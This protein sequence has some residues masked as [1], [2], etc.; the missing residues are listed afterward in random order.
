MAHCAP[1]QLSACLPQIVPRLVEAGSDPHP[2]VKEGA[3][4]A[5]LDISSVIRNPEIS[6]L[7]PVLLAAMSDPATRTKEA[8]EALL[9]TEF[10]HSIDAPSLALLVPILGRALRD[11][12]ADLKRKSSAITGNMVSMVS[13]SKALVPY[14]PQVTPGLQDCLLDPIPDVRA[15]AAKALGS[16]LGGVGEE[17]M[18]ELVPWLLRTLSSEASPTDR[19]GSAQGLAE[20]SLALGPQRMDEILDLALALRSHPKSGGREGLLWLLSFMP[21]TLTESF[22]PHI[23]RTLPVI[24]AGLS[25]SAESVREVALRA[26][27]VM[28]SCLGTNHASLLL[29]SLVDGLF[30]EDW[31]IRHSSLALLGDLLYLVAETK[32]A[33]PAAG[34][35]GGGGMGDED[36]DDDLAG[37]IGASSRAVA[38][39]RT[40]L[41]ESTANEVLAAL[42]IVRADVSITVRQ[43]ALQVWKAVV[44]NTPRVLLEIIAVLV[45]QL[46]AKLASPLEDLRVVAGRS[47]GELVRKLGDRV[48]PKVVPHLRAQLRLADAAAAAGGDRED[49][50]A[51]KQGVCLGLVEILG[52]ASRA[53]VE[54]YIGTLVPALQTA[55]CDRSDDVRA[56]AAKGFMTLFKNIG[57]RAVDDVVPTLLARLHVDVA[58]S[59]PMRGSGD[60]AEEE[61]EGEGDDGDGDGDRPESQRLA[62]LGLQ[63]LTTTR[64][65]DLL[66]YL[67]DPSVNAS[68]GGHGHQQTGK[69]MR[70]PMSAAAAKTLAAVLSVSGNYLGSFFS[71]LVPALCLELLTATEKMSK[72]AAADDE[73]TL[74]VER[75]RS[76][77]LKAAAAA[78]MGAVTAGGVGFLISELS[79]M[80]EHESDVRRRC[81]GAFLAE[82]LFRH[83]KAPYNDL[84]PVLLKN[85]LS[86]VAESDRALLQAVSDAMGA[87]AASPVVSLDELASHLTF[88]Q[89]CVGSTASDARHRAGAKESLYSAAGEFLLPLFTVPK[90]LDP[91]LTICLHAL[92]NGS[93]QQRETAADLITELAQWTEPAALKPYLIKTTG[94]LIRVVGDRFPSNVKA[95]I[96]STLT[97]LLDRGGAGLKAFVPQL[98]TTFV[99]ALTDSSR[100]V[101]G[102]ASVALGRLMPLTTRVDPLVVELCAAC[103]QAEGSAIRASALDA[104]AVVLVKGGDKATK[105]AFDKVRAAACGTLLT[106][107]VDA[108]PAAAAC[109]SA[110]GQL[111]NMEAAAVTDIVFDLCDGAKGGS[112]GSMCGALLGTAAIMQTTGQ[113]SAEARDDAFDLLSRGINDTQRPAV[114]AAACAALGTIFTVPPLSTAGDVLS[115]ESEKSTRKGECRATVQAVLSAFSSS[116]SQA[117]A[118]G[119]AE[120]TRLAGLAAIKA[121]AKNYPV[122]ALQHVARFLPALAAALRDIHIRHKYVAERALRHLL[123]TSADAE[124]SGAGAGVSGL[125]EN[126]AAIGMLTGADASF[127][128]DYVRR[129]VLKQAADSEDEGDKW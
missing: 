90:S 87:L 124:G 85:L 18:P 110:L 61:D 117:A 27:Q 123:L 33:A 60:M 35:G 7:S 20:V 116:L 29:P 52:A 42:Y 51:M 126:A 49:A 113:R 66:E 62:L 17:E 64:P 74:T 129:I 100:A 71:T 47:L 59:R 91:F 13:D 4:A 93:L 75:E 44:A 46:I 48:L 106:S 109:L 118:N 8:L 115:E 22:A 32:A 101:R 127:V 11:R 19:A 58:G 84:V 54:A 68:G 96:L 39:L 105:A 37:G 38:T 26:G 6:R 114:Q 40:N 57:P 128:R 98:Q 3:K 25:D 36:E 41:G 95:A 9:E 97:V 120:D 2:K 72:A 31:R 79:K 67:I 77:E 65:R 23:S 125:V 80:I 99:K 122:L 56:L 69:L 102:R 12:G 111:S 81:W 14:L 34:A 10:M 50:E 78:L 24:L 119:T 30:D 43:S 121:L 21:A 5:M 76:T 94:P 45:E 55:L 92:M 89:S 70:H 112:E 104:V 63:G 28:V 15:S 73:Q 83:C 53:Q 103:A 16:L 82:Q 1:K 88:M 86:R 107:T 108:H